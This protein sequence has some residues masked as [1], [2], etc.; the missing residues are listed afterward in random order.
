MRRIFII[1][2]AGVNHNGRLDIAHRLIDSAK[3]A[4][5]DAI[6]FQ[7]F[8]AEELVGRNAPKAE[9][10]LRNTGNSGNQYDMLKKLE[11]DG[12]AH[13][14]LMEH[15]NSSGIEFLSSAFDMKSIIMLKELGIKIWKVPSGEITN[16]PY[17]RLIGSFCEPVLVSTGMCTLEEVRSALDIL[18]S[19]GSK[20]ELI[21]VLHCTTEYPAPLEEVNLRAMVTM[22]KAFGVSFG[23]SDHT[24]GITIPIAAAALGATA[25]EKHF[26]LD[27]SMEGPDHIASLEPADF[28]RMVSSVRDVEIALGDGQKL[29]TRSEAKNIP[30]ARKSIVA[31]KS[32]KNGTIIG[33]DDLTTKRP[34][35]GITP[36]N[37]D[38]IVGLRATRDYEEGEEIEW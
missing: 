5:A 11:L 8:K 13:Q 25:I 19:A 32:I 33:E 1:A 24:Q 21:T 9:Y 10:Q 2:E 14:E 15:C 20:K 18:G 6:K 4:G 12:R 28:R 38:R 3:S 29:V 31:A 30:I 26:T 17:L 23:Y 37:W 35:T 36:M 16:L 22:G 34:G 27:R 7:T